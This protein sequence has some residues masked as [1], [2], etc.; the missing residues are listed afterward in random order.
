MIRPL[1]LLATFLLTKSGMLFT[2][3]LPGYAAD[4]CSI[5]CPSC[6]AVPSLCHCKSFSHPKYRTLY[7]TLLNFMRS[8]SAHAF[9]LSSS[10]WVSALPLST[11]SGGWHSIAFSRSLIKILLCHF[12]W[13]PFAIFFAIIQFFLN[14]KYF[15]S[16]PLCSDLRGLKQSV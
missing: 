15:Y 2:F 10:P 4:S 8:L 9:S 16:W 12:V 13:T 1:C 6:Q 11:S 3:S 14:R 5:C 7:L